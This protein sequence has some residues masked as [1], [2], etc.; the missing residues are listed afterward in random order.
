M[1]KIGW[2]GGEGKIT[3]RQRKEKQKCL[4]LCCILTLFFYSNPQGDQQVKK[5]FNL[6]WL[7]VRIS[8]HR[9][10]NLA[11]LLSGDL[12]AKIGRGI[13]SKDLMDRECNCSLP[14]KV[15]VKC[16]YEGKCRSRC[17]IYEVKFCMCD[18]IYIGNTQQTFKK[19]MDG[20]SSDL[21]RLLENGKQSDS[22]AAHFVQN[23]NNTT[24]RTDLRKCMTFKVLKQLN[25]IGAMKNIYET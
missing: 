8:Y 22:F 5:S 17:I 24:S 12:A 9:F 14:S 23:F 13:F 18:D 20:H 1:E 2:E 19:I 3:G 11:E 16:V 7:R 6:T 25:P 15:N 21:Q 4:F 10:N